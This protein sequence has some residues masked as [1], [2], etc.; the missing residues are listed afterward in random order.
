M[1]T[2][3]YLRMPAV[4]FG[5]EDAGIALEDIF[6][7]E[8]KKI[9]LF[10]DRSIRSLGLIN[11][12]LQKIEEKNI[13]I[14]IIDDLK[15]E[16]TV[17]Q[18][19]M[20][21]QEFRKE[22]AD[23][24]IAVGGGSVMDIAKLCSVLDTDDYTIYDLLEHPE[25]AIK[26]TK[27]LM[28]PTTAGT[29]AEATPNSIVTVPE[30]ELKVG[31]VNPALI[32]DYVILD[33]ELIRKLPKHIAASTGI[34]ALAHAIECFTSLK[35]TPFSDMFAMEAMRLIF[36]N[37]IP[38]CCEEENM[39]AKRAMLLA[40]FYGGVAITA[41]GTTAVHAL[42][43]PLGGKYH[44]PHG[45]SNAMLL[46][47]VMRYNKDACARELTYIFDQIMPDAKVAEK[48]KPEM[49]VQKLEEIVRVLQIPTDLT[50]FGVKSDD[51]DELVQAGM[52][53]TRLLNN[54]RR[55]VT[56]ADARSLYLQIMQN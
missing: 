27:T 26:H 23:L 5:G 10:T 52:A 8:I 11:G 53:V 6:R 42:S 15:P 39:E 35:A 19:D 29:G 30:Q 47:P 24:I 48:D 12:L 17:G 44:I 56:A 9:V 33:A 55:K 38:A 34:D 28:L 51:L 32:A 41:A 25:I 54:N 49:V 43:Y 4:I 37:I 36:A 22:H 21:I 18:A 31:I 14:S 16:P 40:S 3:Y 1:S 20:A 46:A 45:V 50:A 2:E 7:T 13:P